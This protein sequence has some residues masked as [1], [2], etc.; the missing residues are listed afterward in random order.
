[1]AQQ[2][3]FHVK[4]MLKSPIFWGLVCCLTALITAIAVFLYQPSMPRFHHAALWGNL[5]KVEKILEEGYDVNAMHSGETALHIAIREGH[6]DIIQCL[7][8]HGANLEIVDKVLW[9]ETPLHY[10]VKHDRYI[11]LQFLLTNGANIDAQTR[12]GQTPLH[13]AARAN[14]ITCVEI[15]LKYEPDLTLTDTNGYTPLHRPTYDGYS[16][17]VE[18]L[19]KHGANIHQED[20]YGNTPFS[21]AKGLGHHD[22][23]EIYERSEGYKK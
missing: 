19:V 6:S 11:D 16:R 8:D 15:L 9:H 10:A 17:V 7:V 5:R 12:Y 4:R 13:L 3:K 21:Y 22:I 23:L 1:M 20:A 2:H 14:K 18:L